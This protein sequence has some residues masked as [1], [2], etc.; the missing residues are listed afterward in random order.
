MIVTPTP[1]LW[2]VKDEQ[3]LEQQMKSYCPYGGK[4]GNIEQNSIHNYSQSH[5]MESWNLLQKHEMG[6]AWVA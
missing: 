2:K 6:G 4:L 1:P 3:V 5:F